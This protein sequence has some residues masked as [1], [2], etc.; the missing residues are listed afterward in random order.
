MILNDDDIKRISELSSKA[1]PGEWAVFLQPID[2]KED[3]KKELCQLVDNTQI[4]HKVLPML[5][6]ETELG[7]LCPAVT[8]CGSR[9]K[10]NAVFIA[11]LVNWFRS[12]HMLPKEQ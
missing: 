2:N 8:G 10:E 4:F 3:A 11:A 12:I 6:V 1:T 5:S 7:A 9:S